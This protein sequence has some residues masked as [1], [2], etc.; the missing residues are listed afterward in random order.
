MDWLTS[1]DLYRERFGPVFWAEPLDAWSNLSFPLAALWARATA[2]RLREMRLVIGVLI[3]L[4]ALI[5]LGSFLFHV[6]ANH[7]S[8]YADVIPIWSFVALYVLAAIALVG[9]AP[10]GRWSGLGSS[11]PPSRRLWCWRPQGRGRMCHMRWIT[12]ICSMAPRSIFQ[13]WWP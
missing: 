12:N 3:A 9:G 2:Q 13:P 8:E 10:P 4:A 7:W 1:I 11:V 6:F 5:G